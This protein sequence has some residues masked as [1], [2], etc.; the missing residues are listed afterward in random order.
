MQ[1]LEPMLEGLFGPQGYFPDM[2]LI[3][4]FK[5]LTGNN[6]YDVL[7]KKEDEIK[8]EKYSNLPYKKFDEKIK[9]SKKE[10]QYLANQIHEALEDLEEHC[11]RQGGVGG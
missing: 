11:W 5:N 1:G 10:E 4:L 8:K 6:P 9:K 7:K 3:T 2:N